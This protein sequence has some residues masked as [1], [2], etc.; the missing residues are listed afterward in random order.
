MKLKKWTTVAITAAFSF[1]VYR[2]IRK[3]LIDDNG[4]IDLLART[5][6]GEAR[7]EGQT[8][9]TAVANVV[10]NRVKKGGWWGATVQDVVLK[11]YQFSV[12][13]DGDVNKKKALEVTTADS[14]FWTAKKIA[15]LAYNGQL[16]DITGGA[17]HYYAKSI[18]Q[19]AWT[20]RMTKTA[21]IGNHIF[22]K[23]GTQA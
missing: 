5:I 4:E 22:Y 9:M 6:W 13:N 3:D 7:G 10:M 14:S 16:D 17:T 21:Q 23:E 15:S 8:G 18:S 11:P 12:W 19:P 20:L 1:W 2:M